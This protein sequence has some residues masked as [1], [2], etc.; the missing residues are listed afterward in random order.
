MG[1]GEPMSERTD[2]D[3]LAERLLNDA[4]AD[5]DDDLRMLARQLLRR[6]EV[7]ERLEKDLAS[8]CDGTLDLVHANRDSILAKHEEAVRRIKAVLL[9]HCN[10]LWNVALAL[11]IIDALNQFH[12]MYGDSFPG[13]PEGS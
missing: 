5:P 3:N 4:S 13:W 9:R 8:R 11:R 2:A 6:R 10:E 7:V 12:P 1:S